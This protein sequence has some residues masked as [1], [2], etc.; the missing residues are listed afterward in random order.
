MSVKSPQKPRGT[1]V[2]KI[3]MALALLSPVVNKIYLIYFDSRYA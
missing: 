3:D 2:C 1:V